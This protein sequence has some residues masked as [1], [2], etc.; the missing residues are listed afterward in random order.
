MIK[1]ILTPIES[2]NCIEKVIPTTTVSVSLIIPKGTKISSDI[3][4]ET[5]NNGDMIVKVP[6]LYEA[7]G[8]KIID[9]SEL[10]KFVKS[11]LL[12]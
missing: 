6:G 4:Y 12:S 5:Q 2:F 1:E 9:R 11:I 8:N 10:D 7:I 3:K